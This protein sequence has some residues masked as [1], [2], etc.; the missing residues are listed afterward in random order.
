MPFTA[1][2]ELC[3]KSGVTLAIHAIPR[4]ETLVATLTYLLAQLT[5]LRVKMKRL[6]LDRGFY[7]VPVIRWLKAL[8][9]PFVMPGVIRGKKGGT[10][11]LCKGRKSDLTHY[12]LNS[13]VRHMARWIARWQWSVATAKGLK[14]NT[15]C[16]TCSSSSI[17]LM[18][19]CTNFLNIIATA[20]ALKPATD[21]K[22]SAAF[23]RV[24]K[25]LSNVG[26]PVG[27]GNR[28]WIN[29][30]SGNFIGV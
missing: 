16:N 8:D 4:G 25:T 2:S 17:A 28:V 13:T 23:A 6:Y 11:A 30:G 1:S 5:P 7:S 29:D 18:W 3:E 12:T 26:G 20:L 24:L 15:G 19:R 27:T 14:G 22:T 21:S 9:L 10:Q